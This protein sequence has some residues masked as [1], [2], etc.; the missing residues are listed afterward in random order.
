MAELE[1]EV[2]EENHDM[3]DDAGYQMTTSKKISFIKIGLP[4]LLVQAIV[5]YFLANY[6]IVPR[7]YGNASPT[8]KKNV[9][10]EIEQSKGSGESENNKDNESTSQKFG[11]IF[12]LEDVIVNPAMSNGGQFVLINFGFE[13]E[14]NSDIE[15]LKSREVQIRDMLIK[16]LSSKTLSELDGPDDKESLRYEVKNSIKSILPPR[17]LLNVYFSN[18]IIQ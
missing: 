14:D 13:V 9:Q 15:I 5:A 12:A 17:H 1:N 3:E 2:M 11:K 8:E 10:K 4:V 16:I 7:L 6:I 18:Y